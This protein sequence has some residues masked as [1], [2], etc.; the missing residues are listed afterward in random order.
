MREF[1]PHGHRVKRLKNVQVKCRCGQQTTGNFI[2]QHNGWGN[3]QPHILPGQQPHH[4][5]IIHICGNPWRDAQLSHQVLKTGADGTFCWQNQ[6]LIFQQGFQR[7]MDQA[8][9]SAVKANNLL[10]YS[11]GCKVRCRITV[12]QFCC[13]NHIQ[14]QRL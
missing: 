5:H 4:R 14:R 8:F 12:G 6:G 1:S 3:G 10:R 2:G 13:Q 9:R 7:R 11:L